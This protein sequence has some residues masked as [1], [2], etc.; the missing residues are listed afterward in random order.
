MRVLVMGG[1]RFNGL[2]LVRELARHGHDVTVLNRGQTPVDLPRGVR[3]LFGDRT[4]HEGLKEVLRHEEFDVV[5]DINGY[6]VADVQPMIELFRGR[7]AHYIFAS[8]TVIYAPSHVLPMHEWAPVDRG[9]RQSEYGM[10]KLLVEDLLFA[11]H[12]A[13]GF[14]ATTVAFSMVFGPNNIIPEREQRMFSRLLSGRPVLIPGDGTT[15][16]QV[17]HVDDEARA[18]RMVMCQPQTFGKRYNLTGKEYYSDEGYVDTFAEVLGVTPRKVHIPAAVMDDIYGDRIAL[19][20]STIASNIETRTAPPRPGSNV[21]MVQSLIQRLAPNLHH[22][23]RSV[24]FGIDRLRQDVGW[25]PEYTFPAMVEQTYEWYR[26]E[27][28]HESRQ[29]DFSWEDRLLER[30]GA[31]A[32]G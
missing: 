11:E 32:G 20:G 31:E 5:Q 9:P 13:N 8:S 1:T 27:G 14:P 24:L 4:D 16:G 25:E 18:L 3:R 28:L 7:V 12:R 2:A 19:E 17:G 22:W 29:F 30:L 21:G 15:L 23:N 26:R 6:S 10:N